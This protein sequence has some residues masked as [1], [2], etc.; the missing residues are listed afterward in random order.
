[1]LLARC[2]SIPVS[3]NHRCNKHINFLLWQCT[4]RTLTIYTDNALVVSV[5]CQCTLMPVFCQI[6]H[7]TDNTLETTTWLLMAANSCR[8][9]DVGLMSGY[10]SQPFKLPMSTNSLRIILQDHKRPFLALSHPEDSC[11]FP[12]IRQVWLWCCTHLYPTLV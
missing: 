8:Q 1:M 7:Y 6:W 11:Q 12:R 3:G 9:S 10:P 4:D 5:C 2:I